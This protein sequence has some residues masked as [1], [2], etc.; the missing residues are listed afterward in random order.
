MHTSQQGIADAEG[1]GVRRRDA[2][3]ATHRLHPGYEVLVTST[4]RSPDGAIGDA[5]ACPMAYSGIAP[6]QNR[7]R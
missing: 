1:P 2:R 7:S 5:F 4:A 6:Q 3:R